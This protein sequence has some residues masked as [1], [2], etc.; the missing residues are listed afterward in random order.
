M[1]PAA[2]RY[3]RR[4]EGLLQRPAVRKAFRALI[5]PPTSPSAIRRFGSRTPRR[6][7]DMPEFHEA[8]AH[9]N[10]KQQEGA[11]LDMA[12]TAVVIEKRPAAAVA[13][14]RQAL[15]RAKRI[16]LACR[17]VEQELKDVLSARTRKEIQAAASNLPVGPE[18]RVL[19]HHERTSHSER[20]FVLTVTPYLPKRGR[21]LHLA[22][23]LSAGCELRRSVRDSRA[24]PC[25]C[26]APEVLRKRH[27]RSKELF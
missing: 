5:F 16:E 18:H 3:A 9:L 15:R 2:S 14:H 6:I 7:E 26:H 19:S 27:K 8:I 4:R 25:T 17:V 21:W 12:E 11:I 1:N 20:S 13:M 24:G 10:A 22:A 23:W